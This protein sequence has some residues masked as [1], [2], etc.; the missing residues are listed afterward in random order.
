MIVNPIENMILDLAGIMA[1][2]MGNVLTFNL[3]VKVVLALAESQVLILST[4][5]F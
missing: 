5:L 3:I 2:K 1:F 4:P